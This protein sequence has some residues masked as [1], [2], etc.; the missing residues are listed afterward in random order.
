MHDKED[1]TLLFDGFKANGN[2]IVLLFIIVVREISFF[3]LCH[4][5]KPTIIIMKCEIEFRFKKILANGMEFI[6][7]QC[8][9]QIYSD[10]VI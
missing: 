6:L 5:I 3:I 8:N 7:Q 2:L 9:K 1:D 4:I 10:S